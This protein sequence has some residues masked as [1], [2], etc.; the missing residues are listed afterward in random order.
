MMQAV[1]VHHGEGPIVLGFPHAGT[2]L[3][4]GVWAE[5]NETGRALTD[6]DWHVDRLY[7]GLLPDATTVRATFHR[8]LI[9]ANRDPA[10]ASLYPGR[11]TTELV[12]T[13][14]FDGS[15]IWNKVPSDNEIEM[16]R[17]RYHS[18][19]HAALENE[20]RRVRD[21]HGIVILFDCHSIRST[22][23]FLFDGLLP[24]FN[25]GTN[26]GVTCAPGIQQATNDIC[27]SASD[28]TCAMNGRFKGGWTTRRYGRPPEGFH[29]IQME[30]AQSTYLKSEE[31]PFEYDDVRAGRLRPILSDILHSLK[32]RAKDLT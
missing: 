4:T 24:D 27:T 19:Y 30:L 13:T 15:A 20:M 7:A 16:R 3:P 5:L 2:W 21:R 31:S 23:P 25:I 6:T 8:Y 32:D 9:D 29:A 10:G 28:Y 1:E 12:P 17:E 11:N 22:I 14:D 18:I 26:D